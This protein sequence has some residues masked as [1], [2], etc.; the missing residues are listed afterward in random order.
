MG[1]ALTIRYFGHACFT[2]S[3]SAGVTVAIDPF[4]DA[5][6]YEVP[7]LSANVCLVTHDHFDHSNTSAIAG[8]P[9]IVT[10]E[11]ETTAAGIS[12]TGVTAAHHAPGENE[13]RGDIVMYRWQMEGVNLAHLGDLGTE[14]SLEQVEALG[15]IDVLFVPVGGHYTIDAQQAINTINAISPKLAVPMHFRTEASAEKL[16]VLAP[17]DDFLAALPTQWLVSQSDVNSVAIP[18]SEIEEED[19]PLKVFV[20]GYK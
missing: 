11:G 5:V 6:G 14:L 3:D 10:T 9:E 15:E 8:S 20:L 7:A 4:D 2:V 18:V 17:V 19:A 13:E 12:I 1:P 16:D